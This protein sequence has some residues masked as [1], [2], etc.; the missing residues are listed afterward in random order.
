[1][2]GCSIIT[3]AKRLVS[4]PTA[5]SFSTGA[6]SWWLGAMLGIWTLL[7]VIIR[8]ITINWRL[9]LWGFSISKTRLTVWFTCWSNWK[10]MMHSWSYGLYNKGVCDLTTVMM[11][12]K[13]CWCAGGK[14]CHNIELSLWFLVAE[15]WVWVVFVFILCLWSKFG[16]QLATGGWYGLTLIL[17]L[18]S[19]FNIS[20]K[21]SGKCFSN[22]GMNLSHSK[23][24]GSICMLYFV[25]IYLM[26]QFTS[27]IKASCGLLV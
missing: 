26:S 16:V 9:S 10:C 13:Y 20:S 7:I 17:Y 14:S 4:L 25:P 2:I 18:W 27:C 3:E 24:K 15:I 12:L 6:V 1:M 11:C 22:V 8:T 19:Q 5:L 23:Y 21:M